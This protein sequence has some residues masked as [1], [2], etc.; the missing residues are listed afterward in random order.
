MKKVCAIALLMV[1]VSTITAFARDIT[2]EPGLVQGQFKDLSKEFGSALAYRNMAPAAPLGITG[3]DAGVEVSF[4]DIRKESAYWE[5]AFGGDAPDYLVYPRLRVRKGLPF[6]I[7]VGAMYSYVPDS[8][9]KVYGAEISKALL[10]GGV[11]SPALGIRGTYTRLAGVDDLELQTAGVDATISKGFAI[12]TPYV[13]GGMLWIDSKPKGAEIGMLKEEKIWVPR[14][15]AGVKLSILP[16]LSITAEAEYAV[17]PIY[18]L[19]AALGF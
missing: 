3:F 8:N 14:G 16:I 15:V 13:G 2:F 10:E 12:I 18:S 9:V 4:I 7:D 1:L 11:A 6:G 19:K 5:N 17:R